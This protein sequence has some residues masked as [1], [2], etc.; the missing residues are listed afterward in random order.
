MAMRHEGKKISFKREMFSAGDNF[1]RS[2]IVEQDSMGYRVKRLETMDLRRGSVWAIRSK[3]VWITHL[4]GLCIE[5][6]A[7]FGDQ[8]LLNIFALITLKLNH[9][10]HLTVRD[11]G[12]IASYGIT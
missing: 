4:D 12:A 3:S 1:Y 11:N 9:L 2:S 10:A 6:E 7:I 8:E 5:F